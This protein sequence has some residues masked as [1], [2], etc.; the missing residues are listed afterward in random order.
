[1]FHDDPFLFG[2]MFGNLRPS[3]EYL[4]ALAAKPGAPDKPHQMIYASK[5]L[6]YA[7]DHNLW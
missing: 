5:L 7:A 1:M 6:L 4:N 3:W 2:E